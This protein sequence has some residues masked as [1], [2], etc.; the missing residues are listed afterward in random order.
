MEYPLTDEEM[1]KDGDIFRYKGHKDKG[2]LPFK[3]PFQEYLSPK[4]KVVKHQRD[5]NKDEVIFRKTSGK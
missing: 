2:I 4:P 1:G 5:I 3:F